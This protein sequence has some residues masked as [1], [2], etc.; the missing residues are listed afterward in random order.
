MERGQLR[1][2]EQELIAAI[3]RQ[4]KVVFEQLYKLYYQRLFALAFRYVG[5]MQTAEEIVHDVFINVWN[6]AEQLNIQYTMKGYLFRSVVNSALNVI[7]KD[8]LTVQKHEAYL[9][10]QPAELVSS[11]EGGDEDDLMLLRLEEGLKLLPEKCRQV[12]YLSRFG[13]LKQ[14][15]IADQMDISIK[16][17]KN[18]LT[19]GFKLL[20]QHMENN[21]EGIMMLLMLF[22][23]KTL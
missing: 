17:V 12:M 20:R 19:Y 1:I 10:A 8:K 5:H 16:T 15:E 3:K 23:H 11:P 6:K 2:T 7:K 14:Q 22:I 21:K 9:S 18:H 4:D 13:K